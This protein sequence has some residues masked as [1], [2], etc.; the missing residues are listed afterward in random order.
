[1][2]EIT[3]LEYTTDTNTIKKSKTINLFAVRFVVCITVLLGITFIRLNNI[4]YFDSF[5]YLYLEKFCEEKYDSQEI[6]LRIKKILSKAK[7]KA[8]QFLKNSHSN[9]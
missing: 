3:E 8:E 4:Y 2:D 1:M 5:K 6:K 7:N 9:P